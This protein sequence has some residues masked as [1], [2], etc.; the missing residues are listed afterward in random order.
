YGTISK[1]SR[2]GG[3]NLPIPIPTIQQ[4]EANP[5]AY[6]CNY[7]L[8]N[9]LDPNLPKP[10]GAYV[11]KQPGYSSDSVWSYELGEKA[12]L[13][14]N[15]FVINSDIY[16]IKWIDIQQ[17][18]SLTCGYPANINAGNARAYGPELETAT[19]ITDAWTFNLSAA[20]TKAEIND[21]NATALAAGFHPGILIINVPKYEVIAS[22]DWKRSLN[23]RLTGVFHVGD[24]LTGPI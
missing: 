22:L 8:D 19:A 14:D 7:P 6:N 9:Q 3:V 18:V 15:R 1:G 4:L 23:D 10:A 11:S 12:R 24:T 13:A 20:Y 16:Y 2:P 5:A 17:V 21:P